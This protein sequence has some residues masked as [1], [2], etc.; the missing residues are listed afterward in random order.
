MKKLLLFAMFVAAIQ[1]V[2][3]QDFTKVK[4]SYLINKFED[5][6]TEID[7]VMA[8]P[9]AQ[10]KAEGWFWKATIYASLINSK[11]PIL[12]KKYASLS[13]DAEDAFKK[14]AEMDPT[15]V[16]VKEKGAQ[17]YFDM[18]SNSYNGGIKIFNDKKWEDA[19]KQFESAIYY[20]DLIIKNKWTNANLAFDTSS[21]LYAGYAYQNAT[22]PD[23]AVKYYRIL[24]DNKVS[25]KDYI[26]IY[27]FLA[28][29]YTVTKNEE[30]FKKYV[31]VGKELYPKESWEEFEIEFMDKNFTLT[32]KT[33]MYDNEDA[34][35]TLSEIK[36][37]QFGDLFVKAK[38]EEKNMDSA[39]MRSYTLKAAEA[40]KKAFGKNPQNGI[41]A[42]NVGVIYYN[43]YG[44]YDDMFA[45]NIR[46]MQAL[47]ADRV[48]EKDLKKKATADAKF[49]AQVDLIKQA[50][51]ALEK[52]LAENLDVAVIWLEKTYTV[53]KD[54]PGRNNTEKGVL[55][56]SVDFLANLYA[57]K[58]DRMRGK[59]AKAFDAFDAK[60]KEFDALHG[61]F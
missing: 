10:A 6:K 26:D 56:K 34:A 51:A 21:V 44:E 49:K 59:D 58:R 45:S 2:H 46:A 5:A 30:L 4:T 28:A 55:N 36:Y 42:F 9:K 17:G 33:A 60:Y 43:I 24:A 52:P 3:A 22:K 61:K 32:Q 20:I 37:L 50:N 13:K 1:L 14:Y 25:G 7:K 57:Y 16:Q 48:V 41:A 18:Y 38:N 47:N 29:H 39:K 8:D 54:K 27:K 12:A 11:D 40:F 19:A 15:F 53:L 23:N 35:G 31:A